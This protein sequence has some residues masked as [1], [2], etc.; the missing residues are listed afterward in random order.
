MIEKIM[1]T[2]AN[3]ICF[4]FAMLCVGLIILNTL[5]GILVCVYWGLY[6]AIV[7]VLELISDILNRKKRVKQ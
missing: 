6:A 4:V 1:E 7:E 2:I 5:L 3:N